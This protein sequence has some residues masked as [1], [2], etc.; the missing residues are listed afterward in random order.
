[1]LLG[2]L[3]GYIK[4]IFIVLVIVLIHELGHVFFFYMFNYKVDSVVI[5]PFGGVSKVNKRVHERIYKDVIVSLG[6]IMF[7]VLLWFVFYLLY[8]CSFIV[9]STYD[10]FV[11]YNFRI[12]LF[13]LIPIIPLDGSKLLFA[14]CTKY[15]SFK[16]SYY[17]MVVV[18]SVSLVLF[19]LYNFIF[20][21]NDLII[22]IFLIISLYDVI[23]ESKYVIN[24]FYLERVLYDNYYDGIIYK[25]KI[26]DMRLNKYYYFE[27]SNKYI[28]E[29]K[30]LIKNKY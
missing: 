14:L 9:R 29:K 6:G 23:R 20:K 1:M 10:M 25:A 3:S 30:Y 16:K 15:L 17:M 13:N 21:L 4:N 7:Q 2:L 12:V 22:Y 5:Y 18:G 24:K 28:S 27:D 26:D 8:N 11:T 19:V